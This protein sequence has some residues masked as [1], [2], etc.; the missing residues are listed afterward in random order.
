MT[1]WTT[2]HVQHPSVV[3]ARELCKLVNLGCRVVEALLREHE[4][5]RPL[6]ERL[7]R[8]PIRVLAQRSHEITRSREWRRTVLCEVQS[9]GPSAI[10]WSHLEP[11]FNQSRLGVR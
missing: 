11:Y 2:G 10:P 4:P 7:I 1:S 3:D 8:E 6:P 9:S 5:E